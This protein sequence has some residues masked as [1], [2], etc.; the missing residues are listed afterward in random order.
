MTLWAILPV[1]ALEKGKSRLRPRLDAKELFIL[2]W[3]QFLSTFEKLVNCPEI[4]KVLVVSADEKILMHVREKGQ[5]ALPENE[6]S[7]LN[8]AV[9]QA[10]GF[11]RE[12]GGGQVLILPADLPWMTG[13]DLSEFV[14]LQEGGNFIAVIPDQKQTGTNAVLISNP[15]MLKPNFGEN[16]F[17]K[18][19]KQAQNNGTKLIVWLNKNIQR[20]LDTPQDFEFYIKI[21]PY[22]NKDK[23]E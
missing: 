15:G 19:T 11:V 14:Q 23:K 3:T 4:D 12:A 18:H 13:K 9:S 6:K 16:S 7:S 2:N 8:L 21:K 22:P 1:K 5:I 20:D 17:Q 10:L